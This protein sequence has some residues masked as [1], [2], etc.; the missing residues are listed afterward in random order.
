[1]MKRLFVIFISLLIFPCFFFSCN[2]KES[3]T[4]KAV[5]VYSYEGAKNEPVFLENQFLELRFFPSTTEIVLSEKA[6][7]N[8]WFSNPP[9]GARDSGA[10]SVTKQLLQSQF[11]LLYS[12]DAGVGMTLSNFTYGIEKGMYEY[13]QIRGEHDGGI[14]VDYTVGTISRNYVF[15]P[16]AGEER[17][18]DLWSKM[19]DS[20]RRKVEASFRLYDINNLRANDNKDA[21]L[22]M[23]PELA[24][25]KLYIL[26]DNTQ[27]YMKLQIEAFFE[28][29]GYTQEDYENDVEKYS[30]SSVDNK[31]AFNVTIRYEL[32]GNS[33]LVSV[34]F[35]KIAYR[36]KY[37]ITQL[38]LLPFFGAG[39]T[40]DTGYLFVP[41]GSGALINF[42]N[43]RQN[44]I[45]YNNAVYGWDEAVIREAVVND[46]K[47]PYPVFGVQ[48][49]GATLICVI[50]EGASYASIKA[51]VSGRNC[52]YNSVSALFAMIHGAQMDI[53]GKS[54]KS[55]Y[56]Y[57]TRLP[58]GERIS[59]RFI[60]C[61]ES[62]YVGMAK[63][64]R[65][66]LLNK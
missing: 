18:D 49:N 9:D 47:A 51:D 46:N 12:D 48:K 55:V 58:E 5:V 13:R 10:D 61:T 36:S 31:P 40:V 60:P 45:A 11:S 8:V 15:P 54:D 52:S 35:D 6:T 66:K 4:R 22:R 17:M 24:D 44:Q 21:L 2:L 34:P 14:E 39:S 3:A 1:M 29:A 30:P 53:S 57:E 63:E 41:D 23:Y 20:D 19:P 43:G 25:E 32:D 38:N 37:P 33:L 27:E 59:E 64:Y 56:L 62:G 65:A 50:E 26:R 28:A 42:N 7:G 16:A